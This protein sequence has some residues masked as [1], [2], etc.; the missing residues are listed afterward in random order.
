MPYL[1]NVE[2]PLDVAR[3]VVAKSQNSQYPPNVLPLTASIPADLLSPT[4]AYLKIAAKSKMSF[5][6]ESAATTGTI[7]R[8][9]FFGA[10]Q[11]SRPAPAMALSPTRS[12]F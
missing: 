7:G 3:E 1:A 11:S 4:V 10:E 8:Y 5:L 9:S 12:G 2:P 6:Y